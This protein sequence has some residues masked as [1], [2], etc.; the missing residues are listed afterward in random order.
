MNKD[1]RSLLHIGHLIYQRT[2]HLDW[3]L[4][5]EDLTRIHGRDVISLMRSPIVP[6]LPVVPWFG[7]ARTRAW[8]LS[9][10]VMVGEQRVRLGLTREHDGDYQVYVFINDRLTY[11]GGWGNINEWMRPPRGCLAFLLQRTAPADWVRQLLDPYV[12]E[13]FLYR[14]PLN[15][16]QELLA[17][18]AAAETFDAEKALADREVERALSRLRRRVPQ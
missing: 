10:E 8:A 6:G 12:G 3:V 2:K 13:A 7:F 18:I 1:T 9:P 11:P 14:G 15:S 5:Y 17:A 4:G 16:R